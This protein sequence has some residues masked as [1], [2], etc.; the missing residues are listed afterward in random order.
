MDVKKMPDISDVYG[1]GSF[2]KTSDIK[3]E[4]QFN[5]KSVAVEKIRDN[6]KIV[7]ALENGKKLPLNRINVERLAKNF[8]TTDYT[9]WAGKSFRL[10]KSETTFNG[11]DVDCMRVVKEYEE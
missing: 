11:Q 4:T 5:I 2:L 6:T 3:Q 9:K 10:R 8:G 7:L 1:S